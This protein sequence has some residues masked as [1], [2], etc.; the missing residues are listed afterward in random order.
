MTGPGRPPEITDPAR[1]QR[2]MQAMF[3]MQ[4]LDIAELDAAADGG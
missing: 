3:T 4:K 2:M 1:V